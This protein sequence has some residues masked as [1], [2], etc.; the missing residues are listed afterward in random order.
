MPSEEEEEVSRLP[1]RGGRRRKRS[2]YSR[3]DSCEMLAG[4]STSHPLFSR[5]MTYGHREEEEEEETASLSSPR[6]SLS[7]SLRVSP[8]AFFSVII[9]DLPPSFAR[10]AVKGGIK[11]L[12]RHA[13]VFG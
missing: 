6:N 4:N 7:L 8:E 13:L 1:T 2:Y 11:M 5:S 10:A 12:S 3:F 9:L